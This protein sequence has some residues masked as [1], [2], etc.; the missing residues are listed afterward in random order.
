MAQGRRKNAPSGRDAKSVPAGSAGAIPRIAMVDFLR[1]VALVGMTVFHFVYDLEYFGLEEPGNHQRMHWWLLATTVAASFLFLS[2][3]NLYFAHVEGIRW[4]HWVRRLAIIFLAAL[5]I[6]LA[7]RFATPQNYIFF[8]ILH[9]IAFGSLAGLMFLRAP[10][11]LSGLVA[12]VVLAM[13][14]F[15]ALEWLN[16]PTASW[17]GLGNVTP[18][19]SDFR[20]VFPWLAPVLLG[21]ASAR[22]CHQAGWLQ[23]LAGP[24]LDGRIAEFVRFLGRN[25]LIYYLLHQPVLF[26]L[27]WAWLQ[28][29]GH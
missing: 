9:M 11:W 17:L 12:I 10:W 22:M 26:V 25:S 7:T 20:P 23:I 19:S 13:D 24:K 29:A 2:G 21:I 18:F 6:T 28:L 8:G 4:K 16:A 15:V 1:G 14:A 5:A 3:S 27:F